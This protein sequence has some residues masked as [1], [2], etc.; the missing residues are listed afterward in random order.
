[1][2][3]SRPAPESRPF[4]SRSGAFQEGRSTSDSASAGSHWVL[5]NIHGRSNVSARRLASPGPS[6]AQLA[7]LLRLAAAAPDHG[8]TTP[9]RFVLI[10][11]AQ[12]QPLAQ[13]FAQALLERSPGAA[14]AQLEA[15][16][17]KAYRAP[18]LL[19]AIACRGGASAAMPQAEGLI[20]MGAAIQNMLLGAR[21]MGYGSSLAS[22]Q[23]MNAEALRRLFRLGEHESAICFV[24]LG[25]VTSLKA[26]LA[27]RPDIDKF[28]SVLTA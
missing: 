5:S 11:A 27:L 22:G 24:N 21:V 2:P 17:E 4:D 1:M 26:G 19:V 7:E 28:F 13:A 9:W 3:P 10:P 15:A 14:Q 8:R 25:T 20:S 23:S 16:Q 6:D 12:R 18:C